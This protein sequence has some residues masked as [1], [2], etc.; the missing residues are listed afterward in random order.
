MRARMCARRLTRPSSMTMRSA[1]ARASGFLP[2]SFPRRARAAALPTSR[3][4]RPRCRGH[5]S[6]PAAPAAVHPKTRRCARPARGS[7]GRLR[8]ITELLTRVS[9]DSDGKTTLPRSRARALKSRAWG[10]TPVGKLCRRAA[11]HRDQGGVAHGVRVELHGNVR[12]KD[13]SRS[14]RLPQPARRPDQLRAAAARRRALHRAEPAARLA[15]SAADPDVHGVGRGRSAADRVHVRQLGADA[16]GRRRAVGRPAD[17]ALGVRLVQPT[18]G[19]TSRGSWTRTTR[20]CPLSSACRRP[21]ASTSA[22]P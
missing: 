18:R 3:L 22:A 8:R 19:R 1:S 14:S 9:K 16:A 2:W 6:Q 5:P 21:T 17:L 20:S 12:G 15:A 11:A 10:V 4:A 7:T 13:D